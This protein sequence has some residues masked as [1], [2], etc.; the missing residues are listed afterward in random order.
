MQAAS[1]QPTG[2]PNQAQAVIIPSAAGTAN[3]A[4]VCRCVATIIAPSA[5]AA[6]TKMEVSSR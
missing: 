2:P 5:M 4:M 1:T 3:A 6:T